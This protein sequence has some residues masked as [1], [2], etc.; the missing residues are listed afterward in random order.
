MTEIKKEDPKKSAPAAEN[1]TQPTK[2]KLTE[3]QVV[4]KAKEIFKMIKEKAP[5]ASEKVEVFQKNWLA[6]PS[7]RKKYERWIDAPQ[8]AIEEA[9]GMTN[10]IIDYVQGQDTTGQSHVFKALK[11]TLHAPMTAVKG[12]ATTAPAVAQEK[13]KAVTP[14]PAAEAPKAVKKAPASAKAMADKK[15]TKPKTATKKKK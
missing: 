8:M 11:D 1:Q 2:P 12:T 13:E 5:I 3:D 10:D 14:Q 9:L 15:A 4:K 7:T 6:M